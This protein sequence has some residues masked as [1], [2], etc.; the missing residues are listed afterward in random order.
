MIKANPKRNKIVFSL[1][2][3]GVSALCFLYLNTIGLGMNS[4]KASTTLEI[5]QP[6]NKESNKMVL[7]DIALI[8]KMIEATKRF[9]PAN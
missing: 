4:N 5:E 7:P 3:F 2:M 9:L 1:A 6:A 8:K